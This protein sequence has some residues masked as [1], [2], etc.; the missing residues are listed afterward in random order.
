M[1]TDEEIDANA[2]RYLEQA[3]TIIDPSGPRFGS[4]ASGSRKLDFAEI[5]RLTR[6]TTVAR[7]LERDDFAKRFA[8]QD[9]DLGLG[10]PVPA[11]AG[12]RLGRG[13]GRRRARRHRPALQPADGAG[14]DA[15]L[16]PRAAGRAHDVEYLVG[17]GR[18]EYERVARELHR[19]S[20]RRRRSSSERRCASRIR[21][22]QQ[23]YRLVME[24][25]PPEGDPLEAK[26]ELAR[27]SSTRAHG[28]EAARAAE[29][30]FTRVVREGQAPDEVPERPAAGRGPRPP[31]GAARRVARNRLDERSPAADRPGRRAVNGEVVSE[32]D[33]PRATLAG[34]LVQAGKT[35]IRPLDSALDVA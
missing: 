13:R 25:P 4:T 21:A 1:L 15:G 5:L 12:V 30:H 33:V 9:A 24:Q 17:L 3:S 23:W 32:L 18:A 34:A 7:L 10:A 35:P 2:Q 16:R 19:R 11:D 6:T 8:A 27:S 31:A 26:L 29:E 20:R 14:G 28:E 22:S